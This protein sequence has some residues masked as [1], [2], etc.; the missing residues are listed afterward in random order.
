MMTP[1]ITCTTRASRDKASPSVASLECR[2]L[3][4]YEILQYDERLKTCSPTC[5]DD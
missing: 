4:A 2:L 5:L 3:A 1:A